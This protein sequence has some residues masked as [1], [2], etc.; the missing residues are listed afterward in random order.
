MIDTRHLP[1]EV[2]TRSGGHLTRLQLL[3]R[4]EIVRCPTEPGTTV[5]RGHGQAGHGP[6]PSRAWA[7]AK[8]GM[9]RAAVYREMARHGIQVPGGRRGTGP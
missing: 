5:A 9:G 1:A 2:F 6:R 8:P 4:D 7:A 3:E